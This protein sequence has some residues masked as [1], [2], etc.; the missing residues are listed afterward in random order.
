MGEAK[1]LLLILSHEIGDDDSAV[2]RR[3]THAVWPFEAD[4]LAHREWHG[5][6][7]AKG[8]LDVLSRL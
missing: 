2:Q 8:R 1:A 6:M 7:Q 4:I 3:D 5:G